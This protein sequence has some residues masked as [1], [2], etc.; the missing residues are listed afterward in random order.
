MG[1]GVIKMDLKR[2]TRKWIGLLI[3]IAVYF[4]VHEGAHLMYALSVGAFKQI[5]IIG[6]GVQI[7]PYIDLMSTVQFGIFNIVGAITTLIT[8]YIAVALTKKITKS[9]SLYFRSIM[10]Y[11]TLVL[12]LVDPIYLSFI[13]K[14]VGGG[15]MNG[16]KLLMP[17]LVAS[18]MFGIILVINILI[19]IKY[20]LPRYKDA[21]ENTKQ[22]EHN[23]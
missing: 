7:E 23:M 8:A 14:F 11:T 16:I 2:N 10:Y 20:I 22:N 19:S 3:A 13:Y 6:I 17:E 12:L 21:Y 5:N 1:N 4:I 18:I 15:D 9:H